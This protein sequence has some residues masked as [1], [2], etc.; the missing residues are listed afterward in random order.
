MHPVETFELV[1]GMLV[2]IVALH[3]L[4]ERLRWPPSIALLIGGGALAFLPGVPA[5]RLDVTFGAC[6]PNALRRHPHRS[7]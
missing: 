2:A 5:I 1:F 4:A 3:W 7:G 6:R